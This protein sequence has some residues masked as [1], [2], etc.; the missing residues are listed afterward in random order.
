[1]NRVKT[2]KIKVGNTFIGGDSEIAVQSMTNTD[3]R[4]VEQTV[5]QIKELQEAGC[6]IIRCAVPDMEAGEAIKKI[7]KSINIPLVSDIHFDYKLALKSIENGVS[8]LRINPGN[9]GSIDRV[10][11]VAKAAK[12]K[13]IPIRIGVNSGSLQKDILNKYGKVCAEALVESALEHVNILESVNFDDIAISIK[14]SNVIQMIESY[15]MISKKVNYPLH[16]GV[17]EAGTIWRGTIKS[18]VGIG[19]LLSEGIGD[20]IRV[21]LTGNP[22]EEVKVGREILKSLGYL[23]EGIEFV[24][25]PT[26]GRTRIDLIKIAEEVEKRLGNCNK[27]I[28]V[29]VMGCV[30]NGPGEAREADIGI[31]GGNGEG[32]IFKKGEIIKKVNEKDLVDELLKEI[33][34]M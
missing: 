14:S 29:A 15:R 33:E 34:S 26:C 4:N 20:T 2:K 16:L 1:M 13:N 30:V 9:I 25:C 28:K 12:E 8:A 5:K 23:N 22:V 32:L 11:E 3:T 27:N 19:T 17:T 24:S 18:S 7:V 6:D 21:S 10:R 31:A